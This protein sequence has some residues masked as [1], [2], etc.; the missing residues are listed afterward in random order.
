MSTWSQVCV[1]LPSSWR[2]EVPLWVLRWAWRRTCS[3]MHA[4]AEKCLWWF[5]SPSF[6]TNSVLL[7]DKRFAG[8]IHFDDSENW[9]LCSTMGINFFQV[10]LRLM[11]QFERN[12]LFPG[13]RTRDRAQFGPQALLRP[14]C[15]H[16]PHLPRVQ[17]RN[18][19]SFI[20]LSSLPTKGTS[21]EHFV[22]YFVEFP[23]YQGYKW[24]SQYIFCRVPCLPRIQGKTF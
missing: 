7:V 8:N 6:W 14:Q 21:E 15:C 3:H 12:I 19:L 24:G 23:T 4:R 9:T 16:V 2:R 20:L 22:F 13:C 1:W 17:V 10:K 18:I 11:G 5:F